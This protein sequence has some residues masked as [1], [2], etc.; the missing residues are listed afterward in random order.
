MNYKEFS[1][2]VEAT[3]AAKRAVDT[4]AAVQKDGMHFCPRCGRMSVK[5]K[6]HTNALSR[7]VQ[8]YICDECGTDEAIRG[9]CGN[10]LPLREWAIAKLHQVN[11]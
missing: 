1:D 9:L 2:N 5:E 11:R 3:A 10:D 4:F 8:V 6:L 7:H